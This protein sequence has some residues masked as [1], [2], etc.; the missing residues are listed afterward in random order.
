MRSHAGAWGRGRYKEQRIAQRNANVVLQDEKTELRIAPVAQ[1]SAG[2]AAMQLGILALAAP[3][4]FLVL[5]RALGCLPASRGWPMLLQCVLMGAWQLVIF[6]ALSCG[7]LAAATTHGASRRQG[8]LGITCAVASL[9]A[10]VT[11]VTRVHLRPI[12]CT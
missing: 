9:L 2:S 11:I 5:G 1:R 12:S 6:L 8:L 3:V 10:L 7:A 4:A